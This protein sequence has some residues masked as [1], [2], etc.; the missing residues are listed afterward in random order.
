MILFD[1]RVKNELHIDL[2][3]Y[4]HA[5]QKA[6]AKTE[7][8]KANAL[9]RIKCPFSGI[10]GLGEKFDLINQA[11]KC[12]DIVVEEKFCNQGEKTYC[13][14]PFFFTDTGLGVWV[15]TD[16][17]TTFD[18]R[19]NG[20]ITCRIPSDAQVA[21]FAGTPEEILRELH[22]KTG[23]V[24]P[25]PSYAFGPW[26]SANRWN[27][28]QDV[29]ELSEK[30]EK[31]DIPA[32]VLVLE[33]W[34]DEATFYIF[35]GARYTPRE[36][37]EAFTYEE[38]DLKDSFWPDPQKMVQDL[39]KKGIRTV[40]WQIPVYKQCMP[41]EETPQSK[42]DTAYA[43]EQKLCV[44]KAD[45]EPY[46]IPEGNWF[47]GSLIPD[48]TNPK[49]RQ[50]WMEKRKYLLDMGI[51]GFKTDGGEFIYLEDLAFFDGRTG[52]EMKNA[53]CQSYVDTY[54]D[55]L[56]KGNVLFSRA[57]YMGA[58]NTPI[59]WAG[60]HQSTNE[61]LL[62]AY[63]AAISAACSGILFWSYDIGG[64]AGP[65]PDKD[66]YLRSTMF[67]CFCPIMQWHSE[68][69]GGQFKE[70]LPGAEGNNERSPW[71]M[72]AICNDAEILREARFYHK[73]R[74]KLIPYL[75]KESGKCADAGIPMMRPL[76]WYQGED[77]ALQ[78]IYDEYYLG[79]ALLVAP[80]LKENEKSRNLY[81]PKGR[82]VGLF[83]GETYEGGREISSEKER[84]PV[85]VRT[86]AETCDLLPKAD[87]IR[88]LS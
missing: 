58:Q 27:K 82:Y 2:P 75:T 83:S 77:S 13:P 5:G 4:S 47:A 80:L 20:K 78:D 19:E 63:T 62:H 14:M 71:N 64:F 69:D 59:L 66:L 60:D 68:P 55:F 85:F 34:S 33:A 37:G 73:L 41:E 70:L 30:L 3:A 61:E 49:T 67:G 31:Y 17:K 46:R 28:Q 35:N 36:K 23:S 53:Y 26:I 43:L 15:K 8:M 18:F 76:F 32:T 74:M 56:G 86:D 9:L 21:F 48:F 65:L 40:L 50:I 52:K 7:A 16:Q 39:L 24:T 88:T 72:A 87:K 11:G 54:H 38:F 84:Y 42:A 45:G 22:S 6:S 25:P 79:E 51:A 44:F 57:G 12:C 1:P 10:Y 81:L 29:T